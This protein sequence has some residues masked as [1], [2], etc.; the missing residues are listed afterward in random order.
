[1]IVRPPSAT[2]RIQFNRNFAF[3]AAR[4]LV[5]YLHDLGITDLYAS[6]ISHARKGSLH[7]YSVTNPTEI[8]PVL[9]SRQSFDSLTQKLQSRD[10]GL[11]IDVVPNHMALSRD[12]HWWVDVLESGQASP[13]A[14]FFDIDWRPPGKVLDGKVLLPVLGKYYSEAL[15]AGEL[16]LV[17]DEGGFSV[18][19]FDSSFSLDPKSY[20]DILSLGLGELEKTLGEED[21]AVLGLRG[22]VSLSEH[23]PARSLTSPKKVRERQRLKGIIK[24]SL[25]VLYRGTAAVKE[26]ID[27]NLRIYNG[28]KGEPESFDLLDRLL[29]DQAYRLAFWKVS[30][31]LINYR[32]FF[33]INDLI[34]IRIED[35][36]VFEALNHGLQFDLVRE[37]KVTGTRIDHIDGLYNPGEYLER[38]QASLSGDFPKQNGRAS[39]YIVVE[40]ILAQGETLPAEWPVSGSTGYDFLNIVNGLFVDERGYRKL[41]KV[42]A[43]FT[44]IRANVW[45]MVYESKK[46]VMRT[47]FGGE[48]ENLGFYLGLLASHDRLSRD[49]SRRDVIQALV[50]VT[51]C[52]PVYR[53]YI[54][55]Y[56]VCGRDRDTIERALAEV[57]RRN[58]SLNPL[59]LS[60]MRRLLLMDF[61]TYFT[62]EQKDERL[63]FVMRWQ[64]FSGPIM[65]K[66]MEDTVLYVYNPL[67]SLNEVGTSFTP[68]SVEAFHQ[69]NGERQRL[70]PLAMN[71][72]STHDTKRGEDVRARINILS[73]IVEE[74]EELLKEWR[75]LN[76]PQKGSGATVSA[77]D[78][79]EE[80]FLY[81]TLLGAWPLQTNEVPAFRRRLK[82]YMLKAARE[83]RV[84]TMWTAPDTD[85]ENGLLSFCE[86]IL[87]ENGENEFLDHFAGAQLRLSYHGALNSLSQLLLKIASPGVPDFYQ[88]AE[89]WDLSLVDPDN[90][91]PVEF[92][93][94]VRFLKDL[95]K[96][97]AKNPDTLIAEL[98]DGWE[99]G[100]IKLYV[101]YKALNFRRLHR[102]LFLEGEYIPL[103]CSGD[104][105]NNVVA[106]LRK[107][108]KSWALAAVPR[109]TS[110]LAAPGAPLGEKV[111][112]E[113]F[114]KIPADAPASWRNVFTGESVETI[115][116]RRDPGLP[117]HRIFA[118][119]PVAFLT[120]E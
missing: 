36:K 97:E 119:F 109:F 93:K 63:N 100:R 58:P 43:S 1:M 96:R 82:A 77:P 79:N 65:A 103:T 29:S 44:S 30:L 94:R 34:G 27:E 59:A 87:E 21:P 19:Y 60:Y 105:E 120:G 108:D 80:I 38:L 7:G 49:L 40:K 55:S 64:Q 10:M 66:G 46:T 3:S 14:V 51:A 75:L 99:D 17:L 111:W 24:K 68:V 54:C 90:R 112:G 73:E 69:F 71:A 118:H 12:N 28:R 116:E 107:K 50:E 22:I 83:A 81:Q 37:G 41:E 106:F 16:E 114:L 42:Y 62:A 25:W 86:S 26:F 72:T 117:L 92:R 4:T 33:S 89:L 76:A 11:V 39:H 9:G 6:P 102:D 110:K 57:S 2:Y 13:Y 47:L 31:E 23:L 53:T 35:P 95:K 8:D 85:Y 104:R 91:R 113:S 5:P 98:L 67:I 78:P 74:W 15:E 61:P 115:G 18:R 101:T 48:V 88:G 56:E 70:W 52:L 32:R 45:D 20:A 84:H